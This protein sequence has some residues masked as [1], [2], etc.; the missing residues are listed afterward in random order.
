MIRSVLRGSLGFAAVS[1]AAFSVWAFA[2]RGLTKSLGEAGFYA[3]VALVFLALSG[4]A[5]C[6]LARGPRPLLRFSAAFVPAF[7]AYAAAWTAC[8]FANR[9]TLG[10]GLASLAGTAVFA[11]VAGGVLGGLRA[12]PGAAVAL[13]AG[14]TAG[15]FAGGAV[16]E[17]VPGLAGKLGWGLLYGLGFG[18]GLGYA[19]HV[20]Q[21][22]RE[23][24][25][26]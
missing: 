10:Q 8:Y 16:Y 15:Y 6:R 1:V 26:S 23:E 2:G 3:V 25:V 17:V 21:R 9:S 5:L 24:V 19:F 18:A 20:F 22:P 14:H 13:F 7:A 11:A 4:I 12:F